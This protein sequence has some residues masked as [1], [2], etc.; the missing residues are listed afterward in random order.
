MGTTLV[1]ASEC[2]IS[3]AYVALGVHTWHFVG[4]PYLVELIHIHKNMCM[5]MRSYEYERLEC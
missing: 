5:H 3:S 4:L 1:F 2:G